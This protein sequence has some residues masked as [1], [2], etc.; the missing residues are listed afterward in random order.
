MK[1]LA[2]VHYHFNRGGVTQVVW[3]QLR[4]LDATAAGGDE[5]ASGRLQVAII[6]GGRREGLRDEQ[7]AQ[8]KNIDVSLHPVPTLDYDAVQQETNDVRSDT[9]LAG[10]LR[11]VLTE[12]GFAPGETLLHVHNHSLGKNV[13]FPGALHLLAEEGFHLLLQVHDFAEDLRPANYRLLTGGV[14]EGN[15]PSATIYPQ[16]PQIHYAVLNDRDYSILKSAQIVAERLH[17]LPN[18]VGELGEMPTKADAREQLQQGFDVSPQSRYVVYPVRGIRRKNVGELLLWSALAQGDVTFGLTLPPL[19]PVERVSYDH[20]VQLAKELQLPCLFETGASGGLE[21]KENLAAADA[22]ITTSIAEGFG[23]VFLETWL[24][25]R[26]LIGRDLP[27]ITVDFRESGIR[28]D[29][30]YSTMNVPIELVGQDAIRESLQSAYA[31]LL[32]Q[33]GKKNTPGDGVD[34]LLE[35]EVIDF[36]M[37]DSHLQTLVIRKAS[38]DAATR[39]KLLEINPKI[40]SALQ[41]EAGTETIEANA[42]IVRYVYSLA[43]CGLRLRNLYQKVMSSAPAAELQPPPAGSEILNSFLD[44][45]RLCPIRFEE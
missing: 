12:R 44:V 21:F 24:A 10:E 2:I 18:P 32:N 3:N 8:L 9:A 27:E 39:N 38:D 40:R 30:L 26:P 35:G 5:Q 45:Q 13:S 19:N 20:W 16:A 34:A 23:M 6:F 11:N 41:F 43:E 17:H 7:L 33:Y 42:S 22:V 29:A 14:A 37:L 28:F 15:D 31:T 1:N 36:A 25:G 4:G